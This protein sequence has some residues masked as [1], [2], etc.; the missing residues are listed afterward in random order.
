MLYYGCM[1][2]WLLWYRKFTSNYM[3]VSETWDKFTE[4]VL[5]KFEIFQVKWEKGIVKFEKKMNKDIL[6]QIPPN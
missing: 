6:S 3:Y 1:V 2:T 5:W 4:F